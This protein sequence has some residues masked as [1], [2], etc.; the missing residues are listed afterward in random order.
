MSESVNRSETAADAALRWFLRL[1]EP[2]APGEDGRAFE[3]WL[4]ADPAHQAEF[5]AVQTTWEQLDAVAAQPSRILQH[6][7]RH[8]LSIQ[9]NP[10]TTR[11]RGILRLVMAVAATILLVSGTAWWWSSLAVTE[12]TYQTAKGGQHTVT[13]S[14][15]TILDLNTESRVTVRMSGRS[16]QVLLHRGEAY[17][18]VANDPARPFEVIALDGHIRD[19]GTQFS[20]Y[21]QAERVL[22]AVESGAVDVAVPPSGNESSQAHVLTPGERATYTTAGE[23]TPLDQVDPRRIAAWRQGTLRFDRIPLSDA[24]REIE[25]YWSGRI[26]LADPALGTISVSGVFNHRKLDE[27]FTALPTIIPVHVTHRDG[28]IILSAS[29]SSVRPR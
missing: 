22:V 10:R 26:L 21:R 3:R 14:D 19:V 24:I 2:G 6:C 16:R 17:F 9:V 8:A 12:S 13:L 5:L 1:R 29:M 27:F 18:T 28:D 15:G 4:V 20:V 11:R 23:W 25:R 7:L